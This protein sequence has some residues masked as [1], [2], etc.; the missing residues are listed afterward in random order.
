MAVAKPAREAAR[1]KPLE[2]TLNLARARLMRLE[3]FAFE[4][5]I[6][7]LHLE[8]SRK[9]KGDFEPSS[10]Q[11]G[12]WN[13]PKGSSRSVEIDLVALDDSNKRIRFGYCKRSANA[14]TSDAIAGFENHVANFFKAK[15]HQYLQDWSKEMVLFTPSFTHEETVRLAGKGFVTKDLNDYYAGLF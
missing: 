11:L 2:M 13:R 10:L 4:K 5:L 7:K 12:Y 9:G 8:C 14:H 1:L 15:E 3:G 6:Q